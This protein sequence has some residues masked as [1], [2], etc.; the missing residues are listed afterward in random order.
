MG[1]TDES[2][3]NTSFARVHHGSSVK[4]ICTALHANVTHLLKS[5]F[6]GVRR[7]RP[8]SSWTHASSQRPRRARE[9][10]LLAAL[11]RK[12]G[13]RPPRKMCP[14][15]GRRLASVGIACSRSL[16]VCLRWREKCL[17]EQKLPRPCYACGANQSGL[18][19]KRLNSWRSSISSCCLHRSWSIALSK[20]KKKTVERLGR[21]S[22]YFHKAK[23]ESRLRSSQC[24]ARKHHT[25]HNEAGLLVS[26]SSPILLLW[27]SRKCP[28]WMSIQ[29][30]EQTFL[31]CRFL[32]WQKTLLWQF[33]KLIANEFKKSPQT[34][35]RPRRGLY[36]ASRWSSS[37]V[38]SR[39]MWA[40]ARI[41]WEQIVGDMLVEDV[42]WENEV[43]SQA[44]RRLDGGEDLERGCASWSTRLSFP[45]HTDPLLP[46]WLRKRGP[47]FLC[48]NSQRWRTSKVGDC[49]CFNRL[50]AL[51]LLLLHFSVFSFSLSVRGQCDSGAGPRWRTGA[52]ALYSLIP[53]LVRGPDVCKRLAWL[54]C[55]CC[56][57]FTRKRS[58]R[59]DFAFASLPR[60]SRRL[61]WPPPWSGW[62][63]WLQ[64]R[65]SLFDAKDVV[66]TP[67]G[68][69]RRTALHH[70][71]MAC[72]REASV[73]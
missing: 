45:A 68:G 73:E 15:S 26:C 5:T 21:L 63:L 35:T 41:I 40:G 3:S 32:L 2:F 59:R 54:Y 33:G 18:H 47:R 29:R 17:G 65:R 44:V 58:K 72:H 14:F 25:Q 28:C 42:W 20:R 13:Q 69:S 1:S 67:L 50:V 70:H 61:P 43:C 7:R 57:R 16:Q 56:L 48:C 34:I 49:R 51:F 23:H 38:P 60:A 10:S 22:E 39:R 12:R 6:A 53:A 55:F 52:F 19:R 31:T 24:W 27:M 8:P 30:C 71:G 66:V 64:R 9:P 62:R 46:R 36:S 11:R 4:L 37:R